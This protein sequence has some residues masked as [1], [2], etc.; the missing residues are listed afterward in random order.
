LGE[1]RQNI[2]FLIVEVLEELAFEGTP[3]Y[4]D[5]NRIFPGGISHDCLELALEPFVIVRKNGP[6]GV[7]SRLNRRML[8]RTLFWVGGLAH[9]PI[10]R[11]PDSGCKSFHVIRKPPND[12][13]KLLPCESGCGASLEA[14]RI[15]R[16][17][18]GS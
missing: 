6:N 1:G 8:V 4:P 9:L 13:V 15:N 14:Q 3:G 11:S 12:P 16:V 10:M 17:H 2:G 18:L 7:L 5:D